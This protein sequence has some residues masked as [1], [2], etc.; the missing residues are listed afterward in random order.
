M[1]KLLALILALACI[2]CATATLTSCGKKSRAFISEDSIIVAMSPDFA[3]MEFVDLSKSKDEQIVGFDVLLANY[4]AQ[5][6][7]K[8]LVIKPMDFDSCMAAVKTGTVDVAISGFSWTA[9]RAETF[10]ITEY[11]EAGENENEQVVITLKSNTK[12]L[13]NAD[14]YNGVKVGAQ[15]GSLQQ[16]LVSEQLVTKG[17]TMVKY[18]NLNVALAALKNGNIDALAVAKGNGDAYISQND[19]IKFS[20]FEFVIDEK[21]KNN[22]CLVNKENTELCDML[23]EALIALREADVCDEWYAACQV[24]N[25]ISTLDEAGYDENGNKLD[26]D[27]PTV[28][29]SADAAKKKPYED[30]LS[31]ILAGNALAK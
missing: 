18:D 3:P 28:A 25:G 21:Y 24:Y 4:F 17:A 27:A 29:E 2:V 20:G 12:D 23:N 31:K 11:Y 16:L 1:K 13:T 15:G 30:F 22:V 10:L 6:F 8:K 7:G 9:E 19:D 14:N 5:K 26:S